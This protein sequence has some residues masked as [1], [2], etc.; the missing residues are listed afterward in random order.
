[1]PKHLKL[2]IRKALKNPIAL[3]CITDFTPLHCAGMAP[4]LKIWGGEKKCMGGGHILPTLVEIGLTGLTK[5]GGGAC[6][7]LSSGSAIPGQ[8]SIG[9]KMSQL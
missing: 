3:P 1:M 4:G 2:R 6:A 5:S 8:C 7:P 9:V